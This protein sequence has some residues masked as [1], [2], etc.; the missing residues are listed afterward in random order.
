MPEDLL[1]YLFSRSPADLARDA[2]DIFITYDIFYRIALVLR[3]TRAIQ[4]VFGL[5]FVFVLYLV[6][7]LLQL[8][9]V[10]TL[11]SAVLSSAILIGVV[12][13][14]ND[15]RRGLMRVG[16]RARF[17]STQ[18]LEGRVIEQVVEAATAL[19]RHRTG[20]IITFEQEANLDEFVGSHT[21]H[22]ID[23]A[24]SA[25]LLVSLFIPEAMNA[26]HDGAVIIRDLRIAKAGVFFPMP[27]GRVSDESF[28]SRHRAA[29]GITEETDA[30]VVVVSEER[31]SISFCFNGNIVP[32]LDGPRLKAALEG[33][34]V[35]KHAR[36]R[37][38][39][40]SIWSRLGRGKSSEPE[41]V[42]QPSLVNSKAPDSEISPDTVPASSRIPAPSRD[43]K[44]DETPQPLRKL[45]GKDDKP[46]DSLK[47][48]RD[49]HDDAQ[50]S[51]RE[52][53]R[54]RR[55]VDITE[56][57]T[58]PSRIAPE[59]LRKR[60]S[61]SEKTER[62]N[63]STPPPSMRGQALAD[64]QLAA[65]KRGE[66]GDG[67]E[68]APFAH[69]VDDPRPMPAATPLDTATTPAGST[70]SDASDEVSTRAATS[71]ATTDDG[72]T[73]VSGLPPRRETDPT[74]TSTT[75]PRPS[76]PPPNAGLKPEA[77]VPM[78]RSEVSS[79]TAEGSEST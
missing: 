11:L 20:A 10:L 79:P 38:K 47:D 14:Q 32:N 51:T 9:T 65:V 33:V 2:L 30:V 39:T 28:G 62:R 70:V 75:Q 23:A 29:M 34:F 44:A 49:E 46:I 40:T 58:V 60:K 77:S 52:P 15:I 22:T 16:A 72:D 61:S 68:P 76:S 3:G 5:A 8:D 45:K 25:E 13:F 71:K 12:V 48:E 73:V 26:L 21:G 6:A 35:S 43:P 19:A 42:P 54:K 56:E 74:T 31:G 1:L 53:L 17:G 7:Q 37:P 55:P 36:N 27:Q 59:P 69:K 24:V 66:D 4:V 67:K 57:K 41:T 78:P 64:A 50:R 63:Q 18:T